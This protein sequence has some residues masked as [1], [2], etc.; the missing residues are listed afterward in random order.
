[1]SHRRSPRSPVAFVVAASLALHPAAPAV[2]G[3]PAPAGDASRA[4]VQEELVRIAQA[5]L[6]AVAKGD[7]AVWDE[8]LDDAC[9]VSTEDGR[10]LTKQELLRELRPLPAGYEGR[11]RVAGPRM[12]RLGDTAVLSYDAMEEM[13][14]HGQRIATRFHT[15]DTFVRR[16]GAW[17]IIASQ[18]TVLPG[19][20]PIAAVD[21]A[22]LDEHTGTYELA[23][24]VQYVVTRDKDRLLGQRT[25]R[26]QEE[27]FPEAADRFFRKGVRGTKIFVRGAGGKV[28]RMLDRRDNHDLVWVK[29]R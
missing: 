16:G 12:T 4:A 11:L 26:E 23:P 29:V 2:G 18:V 15:T 7:T 13:T 6:D 27:L 19:D 20:P 24:G 14:I 3:D 25:G 1:M 5:L 21:P 9:L 8:H 22:A 28:D 17:T 10:T